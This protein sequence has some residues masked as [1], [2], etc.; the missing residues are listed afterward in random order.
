MAG[1]W[2]KRLTKE[3][4]IQLLQVKTEKIFRPFSRTGFSMFSWQFVSTP[5]AQLK[6][7]WFSLNNLQFII[8]S[9]SLSLPLS[10]YVILSLSL[11]LSLFTFLPLSLFF[12]LSISLYRS[13]S[14][15]FSVYVYVYLSLSF[16]LSVFFYLSKKIP[17]VPSFTT[18]SLLLRLQ[19][20]RL[21]IYYI[22]YMCFLVV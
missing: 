8:R 16:S 12:T 5:N 2:T 9:L 22:D 10:L 4:M 21:H 17:A 11:S 14:L 20:W 7:V 1:T 6:W 3:L 19:V 15:S 13:L 18:K